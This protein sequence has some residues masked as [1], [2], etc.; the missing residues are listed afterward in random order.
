MLEAGVVRRDRRGDDVPPV[1]PRSPRPHGA[2]LAL[3]HVR[4]QGARPRTPPSRPT[5]GK[6]ALTACLDTFRLIDGQRVHFRDGVRVHGFVTNGG[7]AVNIIPERA[8]CEFSVRALD[9]DRARARP[10]RSS[11]DARAARRMASDVEVEHL[12]CAR[13]TATW[14]TTWP[15]RVA[16]APTSGALGRQPRERDRRASAPAAPTWAT[17]RTPCRSIHP[18]LAIVDEGEKPSATSTASPRRPGPPRASR[19]RSRPPRPW[20]RTAVEF[21]V[22]AEL[23]AAV[24]AEWGSARGR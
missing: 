18:W 7:Q 14:S 3:A 15:S 24:S 17:S 22:D 13:A 23:R 1:R 20:R 4:L 5:T 6:S 9:D 8:A 21:L 19:P 11:S 16:S 10:R 2:R 12:P